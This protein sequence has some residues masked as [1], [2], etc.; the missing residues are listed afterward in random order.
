M[1]FNVRP[2]GY[3]NSV[4]VP[5]SV[6]S[7]DLVRRGHLVGIA[8]ID[9]TEGEDG[10]TYSTLAI[11]GVAHV[12]SADTFA[13]GDLLWT[14]DAGPGLVTVA[15]TP[16]AGDKLVGIATRDSVARDGGNE[17]WFKIVPNGTV[18]A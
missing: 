15:A 17:V 5:G 6:V 8:Q 3:A 2:G 11:E 16:A 1:A 9:A 4:Q 18:S 12:N 10:N 7:G 14:A 13:A